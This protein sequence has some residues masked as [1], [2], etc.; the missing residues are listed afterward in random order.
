MLLARTVVGAERVSKTRSLV[1]GGVCSKKVRKRDTIRF[2]LTEV[3]KASN[4]DRRQSRQEGNGKHQTVISPIIV[5]ICRGISR[6][7]SAC[8]S[9]G[10]RLVVLQTV[11]ESL[12]ELISLACHRDAM[13][14]REKHDEKHYTRTSNQNSAAVGGLQFFLCVNSSSNSTKYK[15]SQFAWLSNN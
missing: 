2:R 8:S 4:P 6:T 11:C 10:R 5:K 7:N 12:V 9:V 13:S 14:F 3:Q 15:A 1:K